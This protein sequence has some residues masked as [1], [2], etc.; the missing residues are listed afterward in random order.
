MKEKIVLSRN[1][2]LFMQK[3]LL[4]TLFFLITVSLRAQTPIE[5]TKSS[6]YVPVGGGKVLSYEDKM[7]NISLKTFIEMP[8]AK[9]KVHHEKYTHFGI[10]T[11]AFWI[12]FK[13]LM[14]DKDKCYLRINNPMLDTARLYIFRKGALIMKK[15]V[16]SRNPEM[17]L[18]ASP[19][20]LP[21]QTDTLTCYMRMTA[22]VPFLVPMVILQESTMMNIIFQ[23]AIPDL[24]FF[25]AVLVMVLYNLF[26]GFVTWNRAYFYY[27]AY[28]LTIG[29]TTFFV[30]GY[31]IVFLGKYH[32]I[33]NDYFAVIAS[34]A[35][36]FLGL[37]TIEF[38]QV[39][40]Q[41]RLGYKLLHIANYLQAFVILVF[42]LGYINLNVQLYQIVNVFTNVSVLIV[43]IRLYKSYKPAQIFF[44]S[45]LI[46]LLLN[47]TLN[48]TYANIIPFD[49]I[50]LYYLQ[51]GG[52]I[53][54][55]LFSIALA[56]KINI[57]RKEKEEAQHKTIALI[58]E[59][60]TVL[61]QK[62][63]ERTLA[64]NETNEELT[65]TL[66]AVE[67]ERRKS[68]KLLLNI[69]PLETAQELKEKGFA[70]PK[71]Y[72]L[73][74]VLFTD[75]KGF[76]HIAEKMTPNEVIE[77]LN[78]C[79]YALDVICEKYGLE[80]IKTIGDSYMCA[81]GLP[82]ANDT[83]PID[84]VKAG[85]EMQV[86][87]AQWKA[88][89]EAKGLPAWELRLGIHSGEAVAGVVGKNKFAYDIWGDTVNLASR[90]ES[91][92]EVGKVNISGTT[93]ELV[94][95]KFQCVYRGKIE[96]KNKGE[97]EMYFV[98]NVS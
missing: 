69:L 30:K 33:I 86:F 9:L 78:T 88:E 75:F 10:N 15:N 17:S 8:D 12:K 62:V 37:F 64:L 24:L 44:F 57:Y 32:F 79:F 96:A 51:I 72:D 54:L 85:L 48:L 20:A 40:K 2:L 66:Q 31:P 6:T 67:T 39:K 11:S 41:Y 56:N 36:I 38:L 18:P 98:E 60:N 80:K 22:N 26:I 49:T 55:T 53:E 73:I 71:Y 52:F 25:G 1:R 89:K 45:F 84:V 83:N 97:V 28:S 70:T 21:T 90:M 42:L 94:K 29:L 16:I 68:D 93:Y 61:E 87:M 82:V 50:T 59:Q 76:T 46:F 43:S 19:F 34:L 5:I 27:I 63:K 13:L 4:F 3:N 23:Q 35:S 77:N 14:T 81:G 7:H 58:K 65:S 47:T 74:T 92:G 91:S 95:D